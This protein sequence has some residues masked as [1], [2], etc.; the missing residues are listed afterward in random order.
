MKKFT[1]KFVGI[2]AMFCAISLSSNAQ[3]IGDQA[4]G[5]TVFHIDE[6]S[7]LGYVVASQD[8]SS[9]A[10]DTSQ[11]GDLG[12]EWGCYG[13]SIS[14]AD[15]QAI[16]T[17]YQNTLDIV[18]GCP[19]AN[20]AAFNALNATIESYTDWYIPSIDELIEM[21]NTIGKGGPEG[22][23]GGFSSSWYWSSS[24]DNNNSAWTSIS[25]GGTYYS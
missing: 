6:A 17:G 11:P 19:D 14:G 22:N 23:I 10:Y 15:G 3:E 13:T 9:G 7:G 18:E 2:A 4:E 12:Y 1:Q 5:G 16:G 25:Y 24:E 20:S 8:L 21:Y